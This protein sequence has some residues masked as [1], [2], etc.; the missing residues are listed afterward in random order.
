MAKKT[1]KKAHKNLKKI[2]ENKDKSDNKILFAFLA[3]FLSIIGFIIALIA[4]RDDKYVMHYAKVSLVVF[5]VG[6]VGGAIGALFNW[7]P[8]IGSIIKFAISILILVIWV[9]SWL[10]ALS[11]RIREIPIISDWAKKINL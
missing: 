10:Y 7:I 5:V 3:A 6:V 9:M 11:G 4:K 1:L 8:I 2:I